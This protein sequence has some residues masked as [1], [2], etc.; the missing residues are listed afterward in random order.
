M[1]WGHVFKWSAFW[2]L[3]TRASTSNFTPSDSTGDD[4]GSRAHLKACSG[5]RL[6]TCWS[7]SSRRRRNKH[8]GEPSWGIR[9][10]SE[11]YGCCFDHS[12]GPIF[13]IM[14]RNRVIQAL[15]TSTIELIFVPRPIYNRESLRQKTVVRQTQRVSGMFSCLASFE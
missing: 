3:L 8:S 4:P 10:I 6:Q 1:T 15:N 12:D 5:K 9:E 14:M 7:A 13:Y 11:R 2:V